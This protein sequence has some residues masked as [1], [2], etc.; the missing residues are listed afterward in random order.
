[1]GE[2]VDKVLCIQVDPKSPSERSLVFLGTLSPT[3]GV[4]NV[5]FFFHFFSIDWKRP[6]LG[7]RS[8]EKRKS[9]CSLRVLGVNLNAKCFYVFRRSRYMCYVCMCVLICIREI[10]VHVLCVHVCVDMHSGD[11]S[12]CEHSLCVY[13]WA[14]T[15]S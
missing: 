1:V 13:L 2:R 11:R 9:V 14:D 8:K 7:E 5:D 15:Y 12:A 4:S 6:A 3:P 10:E